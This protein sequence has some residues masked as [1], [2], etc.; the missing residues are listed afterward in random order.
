MVEPQSTNFRV[1]TKHFLGVRMFRKFT[2]F[3]FQGIEAVPL[4]KDNIFEWVAKIQGLRNTVW[5][6]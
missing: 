1:I 4:S 2:V 3:F 6:G 5:E